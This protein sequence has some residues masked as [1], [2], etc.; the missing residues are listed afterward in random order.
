MIGHRAVR[1][2]VIEDVAASPMSRA[3]LALVV[4]SAGDGLFRRFS[5]HCCLSR[6]DGRNVACAR[7]EA[8]KRWLCCSEFVKVVRVEEGT[9]RIG[10]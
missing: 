5:R 4:P 9:R 3:K 10:V 2:N 7:V 1:A 6:I 8:T